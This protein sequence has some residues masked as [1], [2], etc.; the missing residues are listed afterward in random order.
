MGRLFGEGISLL[1]ETQ[2]RHIARSLKARL[3][4]WASEPASTRD[5]PTPESTVLEAIETM[6][7]REREIARW[8]KPSPMRSDQRAL[9]IPRFAQFQVVCKTCYT[10]VHSPQLV[11]DYCDACSPSSVFNELPIASLRYV[12]SSE[13]GLNIVASSNLESNCDRNRFSRGEFI[14]LR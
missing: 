1:S 4:E 11:I 5:M 7:T 8:Q 9:R 12:S 13:E 14:A 3:N 6:T 10:T 2:P